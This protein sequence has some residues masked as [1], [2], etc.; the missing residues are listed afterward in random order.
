MDIN[1]NINVPAL[2]KLADYSAS[3]IGS[4][5][6]PMLATW[7]ARREADANRIA[8]EGEVERHRILTEGEVN[9]IRSLA[10]AQADVKASLLSSASSIQGELDIAERVSQRIQFQEEKRQH[11]IESVMARAALEVA[12]KEVQ[13]HEPDHD[14]T[15]RFFSNVQDVSTDEMQVLWARVLAGEVERP[16]SASIKTLDI[17]KH[18]DSRTAALF[19]KL[20][21]MCV[22]VK[23]DGESFLDARVPSLGGNA[24]HNSLQEYGLNY[25]KLNILN[26]HG[27]ITADYNSWHDYQL[28][29]GLALPDQR[30]RGIQ[31]P[32]QFQERYWVL[33]PKSQLIKSNEFR[34]SG[35]ALTHSGRELSRIVGVQALEDYAQAL[36]RYFRSLNLEITEVSSRQPRQV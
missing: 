11:N 2:E 32:F 24:A 15:A 28:A 23:P 31:I 12:D 25:G 36:R 7:R 22:F 33:M 5:A 17:L 30:G 20:C 9:S 35:V 14:W 26:E 29:I 1:V 13:D 21:S 8:A 10:K 19:Q 18:L 34:L 16:G 6:G 3:G 4:V 27:P